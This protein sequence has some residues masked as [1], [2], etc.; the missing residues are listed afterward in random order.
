MPSSI[1]SLKPQP[2]SLLK[3]WTSNSIVKL[4]GA[5]FKSKETI[6]PV[7]LRNRVK[8]ASK[9]KGKKYKLKNHRGAVSRFVTI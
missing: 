5:R 6:K 3:L 2:Q 1:Q 8:V 7:E 4:G 9:R